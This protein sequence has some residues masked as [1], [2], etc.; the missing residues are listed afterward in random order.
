VSSP[1]SFP[2]PADLVEGAELAEGKAKEAA[3][4]ARYR[5][6]PDPR[7]QASPPTSPVS[8]RRSS[9]CWHSTVPPTTAV[10]ATTKTPSMRPCGAGPPYTRAPWN[11][12]WTSRTWITGLAQ[13]HR[14][15]LHLACRAPQDLLICLNAELPRLY[16]A[17]LAAP[18][19][20][21]HDVRHLLAESEAP[22][23]LR[24]P[25]ATP[26]QRAACPMRSACCLPKASGPSRR[27][28]RTNTL[29]PV[30]TEGRQQSLGP[31][32]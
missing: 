17:I 22:N 8:E 4:D 26:H 5:Q 6:P 13:N 10:S 12:S 2:L 31:D 24:S 32:R 18:P 7:D 20:F 11:V 23:L 30:P 3:R 15:T 25:G 21:L 29:A 9:P 16:E 1:T 19:V 28:L 27:H 14:Q